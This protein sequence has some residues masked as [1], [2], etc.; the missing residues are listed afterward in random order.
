MGC[1]D[2]AVGGGVGVGVGGGVALAG[3][4]VAAGAA[5]VCRVGAWNAGRGEGELVVDEEAAG[6]EMVG[7]DLTASVVLVADGGVDLTVACAG[8]CCVALA[9]MDAGTFAE[10][11]V[12]AILAEIVGA[13]VFGC[14]P[15]LLEAGEVRGTLEGLG[16]F[17]MTV[18]DALAATPV[19]VDFDGGGRGD[20]VCV[21]LDLELLAVLREACGGVDVFAVAAAG[22]SAIFGTAGVEGRVVTVGEG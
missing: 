12:G 13:A 10:G 9:T 5:D 6:I 19:E 3:A 18:G 17:T 2:A 7:V 20:A 21:E 16:G 22:G 14:S 8:G 15:G 4:A 1:V 11:G